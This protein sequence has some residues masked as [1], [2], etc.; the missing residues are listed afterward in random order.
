MWAEPDEQLMAS[1]SC[2]S[3]NGCFV[4]SSDLVVLCWKLV[5]GA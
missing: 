1:E 4:Q 2:F 3:S 5:P